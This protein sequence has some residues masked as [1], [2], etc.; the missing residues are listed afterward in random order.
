MQGTGQ[1]AVISPLLANVYL[2]YVFDLWAERW[3]RREAKGDMVIVRYADDTVF[4]FE[5]EDDARR[6]LDAMRERLAGVRAVAASGQDPPDRIRPLRG[7]GSTKGAGLANRRPSTSS[8]SPSSAADRRKG[9]FLL[10]RKTPGDRVRAKLKEIK[11]GLRQRRHQPDRQGQWLAQVVKGWFNYHAVPT[12]SRAL[13]AFRHHVVDLWRRTL[14]RRGQRDRTTWGRID[15]A[16]RRWLPTPRILHPWPRAA[17]PSNTRG[18]S[19]MR[20]FRTYGSVRGAL[21]NE[22]AFVVGPDRLTTRRRKDDSGPCGIRPRFCVIVI[23]RRSPR[24]DDAYLRSTKEV[25]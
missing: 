5:H 7:G 19:R 23:T 21:S 13:G 14:L 16:G 12:N 15:E 20:E 25:L 17:S 18:G 6:F 10:K 9:G 11:E 1:G 8:A 24:R 3:R 4:G 2:H 22:Q